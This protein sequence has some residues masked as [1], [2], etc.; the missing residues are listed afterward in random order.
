MSQSILACLVVATTALTQTPIELDERCTVT[1]G[2]QT[3]IVRPDG[4]FLLPNISVF[5]LC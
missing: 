5:R 4:T 1:V 3:A 2:N